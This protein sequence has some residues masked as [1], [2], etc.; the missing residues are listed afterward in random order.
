MTEPTLNY[1]G[2]PITPPEL[3]EGE[4][5]AC[6]PTA[7]GLPPVCTCG[8]TP[9]E[10]DGRRYEM[11]EHLAD[12]Q[13]ST[14]ELLD[15][16]GS[17][18]VPEP[19]W[20]E[21]E[22]AEDRVEREQRERDEPLAAEIAL[23]QLLTEDEASYLDRQ[24][25]FLGRNAA[26]GSTPHTIRA[27]LAA[28]S[29]ATHE[30]FA[31]GSEPLAAEITDRIAEAIKATRERLV[32]NT[33]ERYPG[34]EVALRLADAEALLAAHMAAESDATPEF[35]TGGSFDSYT[36]LRDFLDRYTN[37]RGEIQGDPATIAGEAATAGLV[38]K[39]AAFNVQIEEGK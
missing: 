9:H 16:E 17:G 25:S 13:A 37:E 5:V 12:M 27:K 26:E 19:P 10:V 35:F 4:H 1:Y 33:A 23:S 36:V 29:N 21:P 7:G 38:A 30:H 32:P 15:P 18:Y 34:T 11:S 6:V 3:F 14:P 22:S 20:D 28:E 31:G 24:L 8:W 2:L 39:D